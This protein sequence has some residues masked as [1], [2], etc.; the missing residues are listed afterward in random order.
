MN[1]LI[2]TPD[3]VG[4]TLL[5]RLI[6]IYMQF[7]QFDRPVINLHELTNGLVKYHNETF[8]Q[9]V[10]GK[11]DGQWGYH[12]SLQQIVELLDST[13]H[14]KT[15]RLAHYHIKNR[16]DNVADQLSFYQY[17]NDNF[18]II[19]C[20][21]HN[22]FE[23]AMSWCLSKITKKLNV[24][25]DN[26][27]IDNFFDL[28]RNGVDIDPNSLI[29]TLNAYRNYV[30]WCNDHFNVA[31]YFYYE[32]H[33]PQIENYIL[34]LPI[35]AQQHSRSTWQDNFGL[36]FN[37]WNMCHYIKSDLGTLALNQPEKFE[38]LANQSKKIS[39]N[40]VDIAL[41]K[42]YN[43]I[44]DPNWPQ[45]SSVAD[46]HNLPDHIKHEVEHTHKVAVPPTG[47]VDIVVRT[48]LPQ[49]LIEFLP[50]NHQ[51]F[52]NQH[53][54]SYDTAVSSMNNMIQSG[55]I[56]NNPPIKKQTLAEKKH[57][58]R[59]YQQLL[60]VYNQWI[61]KNPDMGNT[62]DNDV[63]NKFADLETARWKPSSSNIDVF[64]EQKPD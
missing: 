27:K 59:N 36:S 18:Y 62:L 7:H 55:I 38:Q 28:Y 57:L 25:N 24:Y 16:Q 58:I 33:L 12:Q 39:I 47:Q 56:I 51:N 41:V 64:V 44:R 15:S 63:L 49:P 60:N 52:V 21:R 19:S 35:F 4:S 3:A 8:N 29:Q 31:S 40:N 13:S 50:D 42:N 37:Q 53:K 26:E 9:E 5:Q 2:L 34:N 20:R 22:L 32:E 6:T 14:Y 61:E 17:L 48:E 45:I 11:K 30:S 23:H 1:V 10:L 46:Y 54:Q 43:K